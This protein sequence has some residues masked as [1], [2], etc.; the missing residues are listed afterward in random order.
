MIR[1]PEGFDVEGPVQA[2][3]FW[4]AGD[5]LEL[6]GPCGVRPGGR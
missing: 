5:H 2:E 4:L 1:F 6:T 3:V